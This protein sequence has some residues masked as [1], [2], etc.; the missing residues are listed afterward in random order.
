MYAAVSGR[1]TRTGRS[2]CGFVFEQQVFPRRIMQ[3]GRDIEC[4]QALIMQADFHPLM[5]AKCHFPLAIE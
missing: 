4:F 1:D 2:S 5:G 3:T